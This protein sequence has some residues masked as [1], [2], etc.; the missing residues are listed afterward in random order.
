M[1]KEEFK[2]LIRLPFFTVHYGDLPVV[3]VS[4]LAGFIIAKI[5]NK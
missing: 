4:M 5:L 1:G 3:A 2:P